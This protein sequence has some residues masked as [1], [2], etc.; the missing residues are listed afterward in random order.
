VT[1]F[2]LKLL[3]PGHF[4]A[5]CAICSRRLCTHKCLHMCARTYKCTRTHTH[6]H[7][8]EPRGWFVEQR[9]RDARCAEEKSA[10]REAMGN[11]SVLNSRM[12]V[13]E[14]SSRMLAKEVQDL[15]TEALTND[16]KIQEALAVSQIATV[17]SECWNLVQPN[18]S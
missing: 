5:Q 7:T 3:S 17:R 9:G 11:V 15:V 4:D 16:I 1:F 13:L 8:S 6:T 2:L 14:G 10:P 12:S 18:L